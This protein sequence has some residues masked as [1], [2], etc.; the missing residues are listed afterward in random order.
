MTL[1]GFI[2]FSYLREIF[3]FK[4]SFNFY[5]LVKDF[6]YPSFETCQCCF[7][8][9]HPHHIMK[10]KVLC[11]CT[12]IT[13]SCKLLVTE[14]GFCH[15]QP[16]GNVAI[17]EFKVK[18]QGHTHCANARKTLNLASVGHRMSFC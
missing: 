15:T 18:C 17:F 16:G 6:I 5:T 11:K 1:K 4:R 10:T 8:H 9:V 2:N 12:E 3:K 7:Y 13:I 14:T